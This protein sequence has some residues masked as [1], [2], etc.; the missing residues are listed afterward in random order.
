MW[1]PWLSPFKN[2]KQGMAEKLL[3]IWNFPLLLEHG[4]WKEFD[5]KAARE[6]INFTLYC[7]FQSLK[8]ALLILF[9]LKWMCNL[10]R[11]VADFLCLPPASSDHLS[12][13]DKRLLLTMYLIVC[14]FPQLETI[15]NDPIFRGCRS[16]PL[17]NLVCKA[18]EGRDGFHN[19][20]VQ[21]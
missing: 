15:C 9:F 2:Y 16:W 13:L 20:E 19:W 18:L 17:F 21:A 12:S 11:Q 8:Q 14:V 4:G 6:Q 1:L 3:C 10:L 5:I 7:R